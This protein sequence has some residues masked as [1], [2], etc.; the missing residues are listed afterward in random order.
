MTCQKGWSNPIDFGTMTEGAEMLGTTLGEK[1]SL[2]AGNS[3]KN[4]QNQRR[5]RWLKVDYWH[6]I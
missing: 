1:A 2:S 4:E 3:V 5:D 6:I